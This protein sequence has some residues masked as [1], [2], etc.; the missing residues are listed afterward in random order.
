MMDPQP[1]V[2]VVDDD[3]SVRKGLSRLLAAHGFRARIFESAMEFLASDTP[4]RPACMVLDVRMPG[5]DGLRLQEILIEQ[6]PILPIVFISGHGD[7]PMS[8]KTMKRGA[9][10]FLTKPFSEEDL[11]RAVRDALE[12]SRLE[13]ER[14]G[15][16]SAR[17]ERLGQLSPREWEVMKLVVTGM[18]NKQ[19]GAE[20][21]IAEKTVKIHRG[22]VMQKLM[23]K[24]VAELVRFVD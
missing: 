5:I 15:E 14:R 3:A 7:I 12:E 20:L 1:T 11:L 21:G 2:F 4:E 19:I 22:R 8:V 17:N 24:S 9:V 23:V 6:A 10:D 18:L 16:L 13:W